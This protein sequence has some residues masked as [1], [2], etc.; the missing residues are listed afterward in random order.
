MRIHVLVNDRAQRTLREESFDSPVVSIGTHDW[1]MFAFAGLPRID[2]V[3]DGYYAVMRL[4]KELG[5]PDERRLARRNRFAVG[6]F[7][8]HID[9]YPHPDAVPKAR[10]VCPACGDAL[11]EHQAGGAYRS[12][13]RTERRCATCESVV[14]SLRDAAGMVGKFADRSAHEWV[15]VT[16]ASRCPQCLESMTRATYASGHGEVLVERCLGCE[17][18]V[19]QPED[20][21]RL[22]GRTHGG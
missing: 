13:A 20:E 7:T 16:V 8:L 18:V 10:G 21:R 2:V 15:E 14:L 3:H 1:N 12:I 22:R 5:A 4:L 19:F 6:D 11:V 9:L 17:L